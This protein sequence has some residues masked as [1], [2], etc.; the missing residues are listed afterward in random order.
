MKSK[1]ATNVKATTTTNK[2]RI[3]LENI[4]VTKPLLKTIQCSDFKKSELA[5]VNAR[6]RVKESYHGNRNFTFSSE[7]LELS[8][9]PSF[10]IFV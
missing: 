10:N 5:N 2:P 4:F 7:Y 8:E 1:S 9:P 6:L 3:N